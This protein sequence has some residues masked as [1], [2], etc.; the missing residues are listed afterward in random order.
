MLLNSTHVIP[1]SQK[2]EESASLRSKIEE[3]NKNALRLLAE[4]QKLIQESRQLSEQIKSLPS[5]HY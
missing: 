1:R 4:A 2:Q 5:A 3:L